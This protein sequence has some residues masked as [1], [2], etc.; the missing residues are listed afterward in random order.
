MIRPG[1]LRRE[2]SAPLNALQGELNRLF[3]HYRHALTPGGSKGA[4]DRPAPTWSPAIDLYEMP[5]ELVLLADLPGVDPSAIELTVDGNVLTI[6]GE[7]PQGAPVGVSGS[8]R[9]LERP[10]GPFQRQVPLTSEVD[11]DKIVADVQNGVLQVRMPKA[12]AAKPHQIPIRT[13]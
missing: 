3:E 11:V 8:G 12:E 5:E 10:F 4:E 13:A 1:D 6:K 7:K 2:F 9:T